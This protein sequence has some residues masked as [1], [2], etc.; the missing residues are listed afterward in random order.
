MM[1]D[2]KFDALYRGLHKE[3][4]EVDLV[5]MVTGSLYCSV[6]QCVP[7]LHIECYCTLIE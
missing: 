6:E 4:P 1:V 3:P 5:K 2:F 7:T